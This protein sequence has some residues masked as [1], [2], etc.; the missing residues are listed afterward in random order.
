M[1]SG[2][3]TSPSY[4]NGGSFTIY[5]GSRRQRG[6]SFMGSMRNALGSVRSAMR[7]VGRN[8]AKGF[9]SIVKNK[10]VQDIAKKAAQKGAE[11]LTGVAVDALQG[12][13]ARESLEERAKQATLNALIGE[14]EPRAKKRKVMIKSSSVVQ[15]LKQNK[16][17]H[18]K[19]NKKGKK[20]LSRAK[21]NRKDLF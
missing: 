7:P 13:N 19:H 5:S 4:M 15:G 17:P 18:R 3:Y 20:R 2:F 1:A 21:L 8:I 11:V 6:G 12:R 10:T 9:K 16:T 14:D